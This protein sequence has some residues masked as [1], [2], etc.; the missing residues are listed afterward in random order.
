[1]EKFPSLITYVIFFHFDNSLRCNR[2]IYTEYFCVH[3]FT[4]KFSG[5]DFNKYITP[6][7]CCLCVDLDT[8]FMS[9]LPKEKRSWS[10]ARQWEK[11]N[12]I[13]SNKSPACVKAKRIRHATAQPRRANGRNVSYFS[14]FLS[15]ANWSKI[16]RTNERHENLKQFISIFQ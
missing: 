9:L 16:D 5:R 15:L 3:V 10:T 8:H 14:F 13:H 2:T 6:I 1:M 4:C 12:W 7:C 11:K